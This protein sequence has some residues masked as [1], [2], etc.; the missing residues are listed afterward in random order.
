MLIR[1]IFFKQ[2]IVLSQ[3]GVHY[4][5]AQRTVDLFACV[6]QPIHG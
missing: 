5:T 6:E 3:H 1:L 4:L 2:V